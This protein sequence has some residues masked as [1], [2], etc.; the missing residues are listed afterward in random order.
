MAAIVPLS[1]T[2]YGNWSLRLLLWVLDRLVYRTIFRDLNKGRLVDIPTVH[3]AQ[4]V[5]LDEKRFM[6]LSNYDHSWER[7]LDDFG[8]VAAGLAKI[9]GQ[10]LGSPGLNDVARFKQ[11]VRTVMVPFSVWYS[12][13]SDLTVTQIWNNEAIR[14]GLIADADDSA[15]QALLRRL[16]AV[17]EA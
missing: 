2:W 17:G 8:A 4:W 15:A 14:R 10:G 3:F 11:Y 16:A 7:Y 13:Y 6:F 12:A 5:L 1:G 9:W